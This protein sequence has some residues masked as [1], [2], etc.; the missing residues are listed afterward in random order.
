MS[1]CR[2]RCL[3]WPLLS[4]NRLKRLWLSCW[5][6]V[7]NSFH[8]S[9]PQFPPHL[10]L[11]LSCLAGMEAVISTGILVFIQCL[12]DSQPNT[13]LRQPASLE[14]AFVWHF[15]LSFKKT[16]GWEREH[17]HNFSLEASKSWVFFFLSVLM[18]QSSWN[19]K[20]FF[21]CESF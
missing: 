11:F 21:A 8:L 16:L 6:L 19:L 12:A 17:L 1:N 7:G 18:I 4:K 3:T 14:E 20:V 2:N 15:S 9:I 5:M 10:F 13:S